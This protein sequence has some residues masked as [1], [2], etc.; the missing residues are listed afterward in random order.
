MQLLRLVDHLLGD[1]YTDALVKARREHPREATHA[2]AEIERHLPGRI[3]AVRTEHRVDQELRAL[4]PEFEEPADVAVPVCRLD[5][6]ER[7]LGRSGVPSILH[8]LDGPGRRH[9]K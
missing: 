8:T 3:D 1:I 9:L 6:E 4:L 2:T 5:V 7:I